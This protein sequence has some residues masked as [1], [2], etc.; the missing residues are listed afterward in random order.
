MKDC[1]YVLINNSVYYFFVNIQTVFLVDDIRDDTGR[2][3]DSLTIPRFKR[4][5][6]KNIKLICKI[7]RKVK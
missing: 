4:K 5:K 7:K 1:G 6:K 3:V 2:Y